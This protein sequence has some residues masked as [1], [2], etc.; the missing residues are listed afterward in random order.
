LKDLDL[1]AVDR[2]KRNSLKATAV[3]RESFREA[4]LKQAKGIGTP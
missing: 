1:P 2:L 3:A 4:A